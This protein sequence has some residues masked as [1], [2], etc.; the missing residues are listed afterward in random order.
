MKSLPLPPAWSEPLPKA[1]PPPDM[2]IYQLPTGTY[3]TRAIFAIKGGAFR[4]KRPFAAT[5]IL[6]M[7]PKGDRVIDAGFGSHLADH[8]AS[9]PPYQRSPYT[10]FQTAKQQLD[11]SGYDP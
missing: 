9:L 8:V 6:L 1:T 4:D 5:P 7:H 2:A 11:A 10:A 3:E